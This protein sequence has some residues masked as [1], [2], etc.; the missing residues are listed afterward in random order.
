M[1]DAFEKVNLIVIFSPDEKKILM[2]ERSKDPYKGKLNFVGGHAEKGESD[3]EAAY[4]ELFEETGISR[5]DTTITHVMDFVYH[6]PKVELQV[7]AGRLCK[8]VTLRQEENVLRWVS[9]GD[10]FNDIRRFAGN[11][12][13]GH[14][15][16]EI[17]EY[18]DKILGPHESR[19]V[20][21]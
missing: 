9:P 5:C 14:I 6:V 18:K 20:P 19:S 15:I 13:I 4:R 10:D 16:L 12:N 2:C 1:D 11:M 8:S 17:Y 7:F 3:E 21:K